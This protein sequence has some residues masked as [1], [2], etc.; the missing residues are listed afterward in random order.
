MHVLE[1]AWKRTGLTAHT[2][3]RLYWWVDHKQENQ[4]IHRVN[5]NTMK[6]INQGGTRGMGMQGWIEWLVRAFLQR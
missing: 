1:M 4:L 6:K 5:T 2:K 3:L